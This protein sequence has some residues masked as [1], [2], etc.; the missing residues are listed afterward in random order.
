MKKRGIDIYD[1]DKEARRLINTSPDIQQ[2]L[3]A[4]IGPDT[5]IDGKYNTAAVTKF[6]L[7]SEDNKLAI[8]SIV[9]PAVM[10][11]FLNSGLQWMECAI[12]YEAHLEQYADIIVAV[13]APENIRLQRIMQRDG[14]S[15]EKA[16]N[17]INGQINQDEVTQKADYVIINDGKAELEEQIDKILHAL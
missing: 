17:W 13:T 11:D 4:L 3:I 10:K 7:A 8:N 2:K 16:L 5:Y 1:T 14:I 9:H 12:I 15:K 6:L